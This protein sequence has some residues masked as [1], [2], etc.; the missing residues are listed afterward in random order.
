[1]GYYNPPP[2]KEILSQD[3]REEGEHK[4]LMKD[5]LTVENRGFQDNWTEENFSVSHVAFPSM[6]VDDR[7]PCRS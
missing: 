1:M 5:T 6:R 3:L 7:A 4:K 2:L